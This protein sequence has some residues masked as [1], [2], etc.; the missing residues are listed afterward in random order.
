[1]PLIERKLYQSTEIRERMVADLDWE[2]LVPKSVVRIIKEIN[3][4][5]RLKALIKSDVT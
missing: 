5:D 3:G 1:M 4:V 2:V